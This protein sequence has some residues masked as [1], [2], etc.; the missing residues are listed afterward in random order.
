ML[1]SVER[2]SQE[3]RVKILKTHCVFNVS[4]YSSHITQKKKTKK[5]KEKKKT[6]I[7]ELF[8]AL[9]LQG[10]VAMAL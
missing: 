1:N 3:D 4:F 6:L 2:L 7:A 9:R 10:V 8:Q 5:K